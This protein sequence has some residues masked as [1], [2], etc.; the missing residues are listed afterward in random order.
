LGFASKT[1][2]SGPCEIGLAVTLV[3][4]KGQKVEKSVGLRSLEA[5]G[6][7]FKDKGSLS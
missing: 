7:R 4:V 2:E 6:E 1:K 5:K 3:P